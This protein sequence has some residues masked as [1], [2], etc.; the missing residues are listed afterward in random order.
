MVADDLT[1]YGGGGSGGEAVVLLC[2]RNLVNEDLIKNG[3]NGNVVE[4][5]LLTRLKFD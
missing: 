3:A 1:A 2:R 4:A 5:S